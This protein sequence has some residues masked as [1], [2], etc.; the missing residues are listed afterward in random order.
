MQNCKTRTGSSRR[1]M[2]TN[3]RALIC[4]S[5]I[6]S[7]SF[8]P[9]HSEEICVNSLRINLEQQTSCIHHHANIEKTGNL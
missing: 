1:P 9:V 8:T 4:L 5:A 2:Q 6:C 7:H 3:M